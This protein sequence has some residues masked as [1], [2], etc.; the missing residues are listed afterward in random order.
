[1]ETTQK[2]QALNNELNTQ[3]D[4]SLGSLF[5]KDDVMN[6]INSLFVKVYDI[7][8]DDVPTTSVDNDAIYDAIRVAV[9][10]IDANEFF[11]IENPIFSIDYGNEL[12]LDDYDIDFSS[13]SFANE[14]IESVK[15]SLQ[16][17]ANA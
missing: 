16:T 7:Q 1:M 6:I 14:I 10:N 9:D 13:T 15:E 2:L 3:V 17:N 5:T 11:K 12:Q 8:N 4:A